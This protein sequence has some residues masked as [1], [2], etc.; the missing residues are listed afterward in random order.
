MSS[1]IATCNAKSMLFSSITH[2][3][4]KGIF[5]HFENMLSSSIYYYWRIECV[6]GM[7]RGDV[8]S[9]ARISWNGRCVSNAIGKT[10]RENNAMSW[11]EMKLCLQQLLAVTTHRWYSCYFNALSSHWL[12]STPLIW[13]KFITSYRR[14]SELA[15]N[16]VFSYCNSGYQSIIIVILYG[17]TF[18]MPRVGHNSFASF[19]MIYI[20]Y[21]YSSSTHTHTFSMPEYSGF[22]PVMHWWVFVTTW[23]HK[24][25][26]IFLLFSFSF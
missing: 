18:Q 7:I 1:Q 6:R 13:I 21:T 9:C 2:Q 25:S 19:I 24:S 5:L 11:T 14:P 20:L 23:A 3:K 15:S 4:I 26:T 12:P 10:V 8:S 17:S 22:E 16:H